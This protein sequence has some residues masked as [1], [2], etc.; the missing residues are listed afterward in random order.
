[1]RKLRA[2]HATDV[3]LRAGLAGLVGLV[4]AALDP[5]V[6]AVLLI[7]TALATL[8]PAIAMFVC[9]TAFPVLTAL[10][11]GLFGAPGPAWPTQAALI[12][13]ALALCAYLAARG[14]LG[15][16][17]ATLTLLACVAATGLFSALT[18]Q[19]LATSWAAL[20]KFAVPILP[21]AMWVDH[22]AHRS[23]RQS[24]V[25]YGVAGFLSAVAVG[26]LMAWAFGQGRALNGADFQGLFWHPQV[27]GIALAPGVALLVFARKLPLAARLPLAGIMVAMVFLSWTRTA[28]A[29]MIVAS[30]ATGAAFLAGRLFA[31]TAYDRFRLRRMGLL[32]AVVALALMTAASLYTASVVQPTDYKASKSTELFTQE[33]YANARSQALY[34]G[35]ENW[36]ANL[37]T[38]I[39]FGV[40]SDPRLMDPGVAERV[41]QE[42]QARGFTEIL[43]DKGN[44]Y[45]AVFEENGLLGAPVWLGL[46]G[47]A[48]IGAG[49]SGLP[50]LAVAIFFAVS[51]LAEA[52]A[53]AL[54]GTGMVLWTCLAAAVGLSRAG[55][56]HGKGS[57]RR[58]RTRRRVLVPVD[59]LDDFQPPSSSRRPR[60]ED[61][62]RTRFW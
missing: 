5:L 28:L 12:G 24:H 14:R 7:G 59:P 18:S 54:G 23:M 15:P 3:F 47:A 21:L 29:A 37:W 50:G 49:L 52:T 56:G 10:N 48:L 30:L 25:A 44:S 11:P 46:L 57:R 40:P 60:G 32:G 34:R 20:A 38:G 55:E 31:K 43:V 58:G 4:G 42:L 36:R 22:R 6:G 35:M 39:G 45:L 51:L 19:S 53:F 13:T 9:L 33:A 1:L 62:E 27:L 16:G 2:V 61:E 26:C 41:T 8:S 17:R